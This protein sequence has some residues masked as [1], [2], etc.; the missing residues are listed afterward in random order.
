[1]DMCLY[2]GNALVW[3]R[4]PCPSLENA[5]FTP[6]YAPTFSLLIYTGNFMSDNYYQLLGVDRSADQAQIKRAYRKLAMKYH[7]DRNRDD[8]SAEEKFKAAAAAYEVL[9][10]NQKRA[11]YDRLGHEGYVNQ[12]QGAGFGGRGSGFDEAMDIFEQFFGGT[13]RRNAQADMGQDL[14]YPLDLTLEEAFTGAKKE[15]TYPTQST[16]NTCGGRGAVD[17]KDIEVCGHCGG[18]GMVHIQRGPFVMQSPCPHCHGK[19]KTIKNP[20]SDCHGKGVT[21]IQQTLEVEI[22]KGVDTGDQVRLKG[23]GEAGRDG[24]GD[25]FVEIRIQPHKVF[26]RQGADLHLD[27]PISIV[28]AALGDE[29]CVP[30]LGTS[31]NLKIGEGTQSGRL[32]R[33]AGKGMPTTRGNVGDLICRIIVETPVGL[34]KSQKALLRQF[35]ETLDD[36]TNQ[37]QCPKR[38]GFLDAIKGLFD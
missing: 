37:G 22:P 2:Q 1:M 12:G 29:V 28:S 38:R 3:L 11:L 21:H 7:P 10:D 4:A 24:V 13:R 27:V 9:S 18:R 6:I 16:C 30:T 23:K 25:L 20:C 14:L 31:V 34:D 17:P 26:A 15:L 33:V 36:D 19:G 32:Y 8:P 35:G 5:V